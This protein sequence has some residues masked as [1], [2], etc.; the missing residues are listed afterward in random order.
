MRPAHATAFHDTTDR[1]I[2]ER[3]MGDIPYP[4]RAE[5]A[6]H[7]SDA[8]R[9][10]SR[11]ERDA[12]EIRRFRAKLRFEVEHLRKELETRTRPPQEIAREH[13]ARVPRR[14]EAEMRELL[15]TE[16]SRYPTFRHGW[17]G[18]SAKPVSP[19]SLRDARK[20]LSM[21][22]AD[23]PLP[24]PALDTEG[25]VTFGWYTGG[26]SAAV[27]FEG[28]GTFY[29]YVRRFAGGKETAR[30]VGEGLRVGFGWPDVLVA[31]LRK[32]EG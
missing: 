10:E 27:M 1:L 18:H 32:L 14:T 23:I 11:Q 31:A 20:F 6:S 17:D 8:G 3:P 30:E 19:D 7:P 21:R 28:D 24:H 13:L 12:E 2:D 5:D 25:E 9:T 22:P 29:F 16:L 26:L 15:E 4:A